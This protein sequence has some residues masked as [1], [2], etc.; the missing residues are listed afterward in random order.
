MLPVSEQALFV[1]FPAL[2]LS[3]T[4][5]PDVDEADSRFDPFTLPVAGALNVIV[6]G[7]GTTTFTTELSARPAPFSATTA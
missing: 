5:R 6:C 1:V 4:V 2:R 3:P 7:C